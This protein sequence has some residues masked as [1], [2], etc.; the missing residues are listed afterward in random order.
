MNKEK[1]ERLGIKELLDQ[2]KKISNTIMIV[3]FSLLVYGSVLFYLMYNGN[4]Q[5]GDFLF[6]IPVIGLLLAF[7]AGRNFN[8]INAEVQKRLK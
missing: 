2:K 4:K 7:Y 8:L 3:L 1:Y 5:A 6:F